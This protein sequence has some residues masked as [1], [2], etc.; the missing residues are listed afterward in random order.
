MVKKLI[1]IQAM[2]DFDVLAEA[3]LFPVIAM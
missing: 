1:G 2:D 3:A